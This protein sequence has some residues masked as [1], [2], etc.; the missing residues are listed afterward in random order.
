LREDIVTGSYS[1]EELEES[2][3]KIDAI[4]NKLQQLN[5]LPE[6]PVQNRFDIAYDG[7]TFHLTLGPDEI[8]FQNNSR[9]ENCI[10]I[11]ILEDIELLNYYYYYN[12]LQR[13]PYIPHAVFFKFI[14][15]LG[16][17]YNKDVTLTDLSSK[18]IE[19]TDC[20]ISAIVF[21]MSG[22][23]TF[24]QRF[25]FVNE[26]YDAFIKETKQM[27]FAVFMK[28][29]GHDEN[30]EQML[31]ILRA[32]G[33]NGQS[34]MRHIAKTIVSKCKKTS[35]RK[36]RQLKSTRSSFSR[37]TSSYATASTEDIAKLAS[38]IELSFN[39]MVL[40]LGVSGLYHFRFRARV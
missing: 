34:T 32:M 16:I 17:V 7:Y 25:G 24:Y 10:E 40:K 1:T 31:R 35:V 37:K 26:D 6:L 3:R 30:H 39:R 11:M 5:E 22:L 20:N 18:Q 2:Q 9:T 33:L 23:Q 28:K 14:K 4:A 29:A 38:V 8:L 15:Q 12:N 13:C 36:S 21:S 19:H 27:S